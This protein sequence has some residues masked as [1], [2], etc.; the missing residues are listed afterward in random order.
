MNTVAINR[1]SNFKAEILIVNEYIKL[2]IS[3]A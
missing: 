3:R 1:D 2:I